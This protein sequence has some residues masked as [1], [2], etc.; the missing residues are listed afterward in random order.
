M[1]E[2]GIKERIILAK[3]IEQLTELLKEVIKW[4]P[5]RKLASKCLIA[6]ERNWF[7]PNKSKPS[8][9]DAKEL[10]AMGY[11]NFS[12]YHEN[13]VGLERV[14]ASIWEYNP[15][16]ERDEYFEA[17]EQLIKFRTYGSEYKPKRKG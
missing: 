1:S 16:E 7:H 5:D 12:E 9:W 10:H 4:K 13:E 14:G 6:A 11:D 8:K 3:S 17:E 2:E 15:Y